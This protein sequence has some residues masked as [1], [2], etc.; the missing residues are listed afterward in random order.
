MN[1]EQERCPNSI[2][3]R[4]TNLNNHDIRIDEESCCVTSVDF[5]IISIPVKC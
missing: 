4:P 5:R 2:S 1:A 3:A